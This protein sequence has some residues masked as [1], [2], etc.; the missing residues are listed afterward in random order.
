M[1]KSYKKPKYDSDNRKKSF[2][3]QKQRRREEDYNEQVCDS[4]ETED[5]TFKYY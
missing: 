1:S 4:S 3:K 2:K 5:Q